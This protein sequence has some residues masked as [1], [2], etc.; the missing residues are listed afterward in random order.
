MTSEQ[1]ETTV[2]E[3]AVPSVGEQLKS[4]RLAQGKGL[5]VVAKALHLD[6][7]TVLAIETDDQQSLPAAIF[8]QGYIQNYA[9]LLGV[10]A[11]PLLALYRQ[12]APTEPE[13]ELRG[14]RN[15]GKLLRSD[16]AMRFTR[17]RSSLLLV[18]FFILL[19]LVLAGIIWWFWSQSFSSS[20]VISGVEERV[21]LMPQGGAA[22]IITTTVITAAET[23][24]PPEAVVVENRPE[25]IPRS[26]KEPEM[27]AVVETPEPLPQL[28]EVV[29]DKV[30]LDKLV[31]R[32]EKDSWI[33]IFDADKKRVMYRLLRGGQS[34]E[35]EGV[36]PFSV[37]LG[38][39]H[40]VELSINGEVFDISPFIVK[41]S[42]RF[43][44]ERP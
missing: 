37:L 44:V 18:S 27:P 2:S 21:I 4:A 6:V 24:K 10:P 13:L 16:K 41:N 22:A 35:M 33:E 3:K 8:V 9:H 17:R 31:I 23:T 36:A 11:E 25:S 32:S 28:A 20:P 29:P 26:I 40:D 39:A 15:K 1:V 12:H 19:G 42:A 43:R 5:S 34:R 38:Y 7:A 30:M 14:P